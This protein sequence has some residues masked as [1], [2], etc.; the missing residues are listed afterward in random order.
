MAWTMIVL[1]GMIAAALGLV[2]AA[3]ARERFD[4]ANAATE[5][6]H[7]GNSGTLAEMVGGLPVE[8]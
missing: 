5:V 3:E 1:M 6:K 2:A 7:S 4:A 8:R